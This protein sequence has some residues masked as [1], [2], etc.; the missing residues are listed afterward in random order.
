MGP[1]VISVIE[2]L[3]ADM[4]LFVDRMPDPGE[5]IKV[6]NS[7]EACGGKGANAAV[8]AYRTCHRRPAAPVTLDQPPSE[9]TT[10]EVA[11]AI[12]ELPAATQDASDIQVRMVGAVGEDLDAERFQKQFEQNGINTAGI[13]KVPGGRTALGY[14]IVEQFTGENRCLF[15]EGA[16]AIWKKEDFLALESLAPGGPRPNLVVAQLEINNEVVQQAILTAGKA[17][18]EFCLNAAPAEQI[19]WACY[20]YLTHLLVNETEAAILT[21]RYPKEVHQ[22]TWAE[23][24]DELLERGA[25][26]VVITLGE[27]GAYYANASDRGHA[28][29][30]EVPVVDV[31]GAGYVILGLRRPFW[32]KLTIRGIPLRAPTPPNTCVKRL[33]GRLGIFAAPSPTQTRPRHSSSASEVARKA[34]LGR[35]TLISSKQS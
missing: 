13:R 8:A 19:A 10:E 25:R 32:S 9:V 14:A 22:D 7:H 30:H 35:M 16:D 29:A 12:T 28:P 21:G 33:L 3:H 26:N 27:R 34:S 1:Q 24:A 31:T 18:I 5:T 20:R 4:L 11:P 17:G 6:I 23:I 2:A 15:L